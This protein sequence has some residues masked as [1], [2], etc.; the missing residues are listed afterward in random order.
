ML[1]ARLS[2][3]EGRDARTETLAFCPNLT[4]SLAFSAYYYSS[5]RAFLVKQFF[6]LNFGLSLMADVFV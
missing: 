1:A 2:A 5:A 4:G 3:D 6:V